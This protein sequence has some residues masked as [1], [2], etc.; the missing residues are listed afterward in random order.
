MGKL[1]KSSSEKPGYAKWS[2]SALLPRS[3]KKKYGCVDPNMEKARVINCTLLNMGILSANKIYH[4]MA[5]NI[6]I[7]SWIILYGWIEHN[8][9]MVCLSNCMLELRNMSRCYCLSILFNQWF[10]TIWTVSKGLRFYV[11]Q[12]DEQQQHHLLRR[13]QLQRHV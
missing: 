13:R 11:L 12:R 5:H 3:A 2:S 9:Q 7:V 6:N 4:A 10:P 8:I 1:T